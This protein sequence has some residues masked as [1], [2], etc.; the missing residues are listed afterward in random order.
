M[1]WV[2]GKSGKPLSGNRAAIEI[3]KRADIVVETM[4]LLFSPELVEIQQAGTRILTCIEPVELLARLFPTEDLRRRVDAAAELLG[5]ART[6]RFTNRAGTDV[7]Y[8][9]GIY[10]VQPSTASR[11][12]P[13]A[14]TTGPRAA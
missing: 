11:T 13:A 8:E 1:G 7:S 14:G 12:P 9:L 10:P 5:A 3:L 6:L 2:S 4:F